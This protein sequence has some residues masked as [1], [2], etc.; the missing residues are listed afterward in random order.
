MLID[1]GRP[2]SSCGSNQAASV[3][4]VPS[5]VI[6]PER[7]R[8][9]NPIMSECGKGHGWLAKYRISVNSTPTSSPTSWAT[10]SSRVSPGSTN[11]ARQE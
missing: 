10:A 11:P 1:D 7:H 5:T 8:A 3:I 6:S 9:V 2:G 4:S